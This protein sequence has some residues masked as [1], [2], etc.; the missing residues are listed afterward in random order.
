LAHGPEGEGHAR[1]DGWIREAKLFP[2]FN[3]CDQT[4]PELNTDWK[5]VIVH[6]GQFRG[7]FTNHALFCEAL[8]ND[9]INK[10]IEYLRGF[11]SNASWP[12]R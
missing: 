1:I 2:D 7:L 3:A 5:A 12:P 4:T 11:C 6:G 9:Q 10:V 8:T